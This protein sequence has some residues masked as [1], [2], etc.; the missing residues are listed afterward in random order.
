MVGY[1]LVAGD[2]QSSELITPYLWKDY[3]LCTLLKKEIR[4]RQ[5]GNDLTLL[6]IKYYIEGKFS[7]YMPVH[8][9]SKI[10]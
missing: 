5:Y 9:N 2:E 6:L 3:G 4:N 1:Y 8:V 7:G 10:I